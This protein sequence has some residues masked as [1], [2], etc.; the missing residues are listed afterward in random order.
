[1]NLYEKLRRS[2]I[3]RDDVIARAVLTPAVSTMIS[4]GSVHDSEL[5]QLTNLCSFSPIFVPYDAQALSSLV[6]DI[7]GKIEAEGHDAVIAQAAEHL[8]PSLRET[9]LCFAAR[10]ALA[11]GRL[12]DGEKASL[13]QTGYHMQI[14]ASIFEKVIE[15]VAMMQRPANA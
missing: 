11:D 7:I 1:M 5:S 12:D 4:D 14:P 13:A 8:S 3:G 2:S 9:A 6:Q 10:I 15:V